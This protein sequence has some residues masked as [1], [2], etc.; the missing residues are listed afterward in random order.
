MPALEASMTLTK[1]MMMLTIFLWLELRFLVGFSIFL[2]HYTAL[3]EIIFKLFDL[4][5]CWLKKDETH[6]RILAWILFWKLQRKQNN[7]ELQNCLHMLMQRTNKQ[8]DQAQTV[9]IGLELECHVF[10]QWSSWNIWPISTSAWFWI[11]KYLSDLLFE[12][13]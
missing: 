9:Y 13:S 11:S 5:Y 1:A 6:V 7:K 3:L 10:T 4:A 2:V 12:M 8:T